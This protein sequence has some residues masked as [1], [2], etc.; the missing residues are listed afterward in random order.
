MN[1]PENVPR[2]TLR[3]LEAPTGKPILA[4]LLTLL[5]GA[6]CFAQSSLAPP[7]PPAD[8]RYKADILLI[9]AH[10]DDEALVTGYLARAIYDEHKR[11]AVLYGTCGGAG[12]NA[13]T[14]EQAA[15]LCAV[16]RIEARRALASL[17]IMNV[18]FL[19]GL[20]TPTQNVLESLEHW[21]HGAA[22]ERAV[23][24]VRL[25]RPEVILTWL[26]DFVDGENHGDHQAAAVIATEAFD[27]AGNPTVFPEQVAAPPNYKLIGNLTEGLRPWQ[28]QKL[29]YFSN[30]AHS[31]FE[32]GQG[33]EYS[34]T[35]VSPSRH[36]PYYQIAA[37]SLS[38]HLTQESAGAEG[39]TTT[40]NSILPSFK[41]PVR[42]ILA[43]SLVETATTGDIFQGVVPGPIPFHPITGYRPEPHSGLSIDL[44]G[45]WAFYRQFWRAHDMAHIARLVSPEAGVGSG[46]TFS[47]PVIIR[48]DT[49]S[50][51]RV[52]LSAVV[53]AG[54]KVASAPAIY[55][56]NANG[57]YPARIVFVAPAGSRPEWQTLMVNAQSNG[58]PVGSIAFRV[59]YGQSGPAPP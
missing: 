56:V 46:E 29:Y 30:A 49:S 28:P 51:A 7:S 8:R 16:R 9:V 50:A 37:E 19:G 54:W 21:N 13:V 11:V 31:D 20:D 12:G 33:P 17:G 35:D 52:E 42:F 14:Y 48:N 24:L 53:P 1:M 6:G 32:N 4:L 45:P 38:Y 18:W 44:G 39:R 23:R 43:K 41:H 55:P 57:L 34:T 10:P 22:L 59:S 2:S 27:L 26:P 40:F 58:K 47:L 25:T 3:A 36:V 15:S 5:L